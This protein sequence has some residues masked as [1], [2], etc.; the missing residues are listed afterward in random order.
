VAAEH[1][2]EARLRLP[3]LMAAL[4]RRVREAHAHQVAAY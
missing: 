1:A 4:Q 2:A 3:L